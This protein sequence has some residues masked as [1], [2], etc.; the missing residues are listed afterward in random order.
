MCVY[1]VVPVFRYYF[2][3]CESWAWFYPYHYAPLVADLA[4]FLGSNP[5]HASLGELK[6]GRPFNPLAQL[7][8]VLPATSS[9]CLPDSY[10]ALMTA[11]DSPLL[12]QY[13]ATF[14]MD[15]NG[16]RWEHEAVAL[17][18]IVDEA[19]LLKTLATVAHTRTAQEVKRDSARPATLF[20]ADGHDLTPVL[21]HGLSRAPWGFLARLGCCGHVSSAEISEAK[22]VTVCQFQ[23]P[24][25]DSPFITP[26]LALESCDPPSVTCAAQ[27]SAL[28]PGVLDL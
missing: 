11:A 8:A 15:M 18:P 26:P 14:V 22:G 7:M 12:A 21:A 27:S 13:P 24:L 19:L 17:L 23:L 6:Q 20:C 5:S 25:R 10:A 2:A 16:A 28:R 3:G 1:T 4:S 9:T